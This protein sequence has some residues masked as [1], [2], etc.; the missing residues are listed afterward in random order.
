MVNTR[1]EKTKKE[2]DKTK[3]KISELQ[4]KLQ[5]LEALKTELENSQII[6]LVRSGNV[7]TSELSEI[8]AA[9]R[10]GKDVNLIDQKISVSEEV[11]SN[12]N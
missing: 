2:I 8:I 6:S 1:L 12:A 4:V 3:L 11:Y 5:E 9:I 7:S 10:S